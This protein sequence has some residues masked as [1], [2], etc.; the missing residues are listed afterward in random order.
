MQHN[1][2]SDSKAETSSQNTIQ[3]DLKAHSSKARNRTANDSV[4]RGRWNPQT[5]RKV[6][7]SDLILKL[8]RQK[9]GTT[10]EA[11]AEVTGWQAHSV[12]GFLSGTVKKKLG[13]PLASDIGKDGKRRYSIAMDTTAGEQ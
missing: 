8:L 4:R 12:R 7:K 10:I 2:N 3:P 1:V 13:L 11:L 6:S 5:E 9:N